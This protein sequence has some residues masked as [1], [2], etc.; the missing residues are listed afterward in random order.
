MLAD[1]ALGKFRVGDV[2]RRVADPPREP[3]KRQILCRA[4]G[5]YLSAKS[6]GARSVGID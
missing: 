5:A 3:V 2:L 6:S 4:A 1:G